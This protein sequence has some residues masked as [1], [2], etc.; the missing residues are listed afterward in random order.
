MSLYKGN[1]L[2]SGHQVL[3]SVT[4][5][6]IDGAM[7]QKACTDNF[8]TNDLSNLTT[9]YCNNFDGQWVNSV[10]QLALS[11]TAPTTTDIEYDLSS[12]LPNDNYS[13]EVLFTGTVATGSTSGNNA[14][15]TLKS[16]N[17]DSAYLCRAQTRSSSTVSGSGC[18][19][20]PIGSDH[21]VTVSAWSNNT[22][23][24]ALSAMAY[25]RIGTNA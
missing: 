21:K 15:L 11:V 12:Y 14:R 2:I 22:G 24:F 20:L 1:T 6:N 10:M 3:Y 18:A 17:I 8:A 9:T 23:T 7:T 16:Q 25:R 4:G 19:I 13:Y 5:S